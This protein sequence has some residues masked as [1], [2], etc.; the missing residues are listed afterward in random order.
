MP[1]RSA[2]PAPPPTPTYLRRGK[3]KE[4]YEVSPTELEFRFTNDISVFDK[5]IPSEIPHKGET[6]NLTAS[7]WFE[8]CS[9]LKIPHHY[10]GRSSP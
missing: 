4:V 9:R 2:T 5:H 8:M 1:A 10:L 6:L 7:H 3:V